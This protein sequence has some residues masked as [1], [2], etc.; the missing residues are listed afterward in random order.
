VLWI[1]FCFFLTIAYA[2]IMAV[3]LYGWNK[4]PEW[5]APEDFVP[6]TAVTVVIP[7]R[8]EEK[9]LDACLESVLGGDYPPTLL[10]CIVVDD[11][12]DDGTAPLVRRWQDRY[13][14]LRL[15]ALADCP[16]PDGRPVHGKKKALEAAAARAAGELIVTTDADCL[17]PPGWLRIIVSAY[18]SGRWKAVAAPVVV[19]D[20]P[21]PVQRFQALD[22][23]GMMGIT[24]AGLHLGFQRLG[25]GANLA[26]PR[27]LFAELGGYAGSDGLASG[28]DLFFLQKVE[29]RHPGSVGFLK[30]AAAAV[31]TPAL[32]DWSTFWQQRLRWGTKNAALPEVP[33][34]IVLALVFLF[35]W[36]I[37][38][39]AL[40]ILRSPGFA[41][42]LLLQLSIK[43]LWDNLFLS[44]LARFFNRPHYLRRFWPSFFLHIAYIAGIGLASLFVRR[45][46][47]KGRQVE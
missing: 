32:P 3:Y 45:Y 24:G 25:N 34:R 12:S 8:N 1:L 16:G 14:T 30:N 11:H 19:E 7:A 22:M 15:L 44:A 10:E 17:V 40:L 23:L 36:T 39:N 37:I 6:Q 9:N 41:F 28:D 42:L 35:C 21:R 26:Y 31:R 33:V 38:I 27:A 13:P 5:S 4:L 46:E 2:A 47:W 20:G 18:E 29:R 43:A